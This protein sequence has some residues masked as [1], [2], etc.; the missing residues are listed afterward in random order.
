[1]H[2]VNCNAEISFKYSMCSELP[3]TVNQQCC[4]YSATAVH[5]LCKGSC[6]LQ[7]FW[8]VSMTLSLAAWKLNICCHNAANRLEN[9]AT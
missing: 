6:H 1:M 8:S 7:L 4:D 3:N 9:L 2:V 5:F